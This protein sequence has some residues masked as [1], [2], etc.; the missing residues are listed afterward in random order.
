[1]KSKI[2][3]AV[4]VINAALIVLSCAA[5]FKTYVAWVDQGKF[6]LSLAAVTLICGFAGFF[7][8][9][10]GNGSKK[11][12]I[13]YAVGG[14]AAAEVIFWGFG[15]VIN[16]LIG[17]GGLNKLAG[18]IAVAVIIV[19]YGIVSVLTYKNLNTE[20]KKSVKVLSGVLAAVLAGM[21]V[22]QAGNMAV[23][24]RRATEKNY[25][26]ANECYR[27]D[28]DFY[29]KLKNKEDVNVLII[30]DSIGEGAGGEYG[31]WFQLLENAVEK[32]YGVNYRTR[33]VSFGGNAAYCG[34]VSSKIFADR[35]D[36][37]LAV[38]CYSQNDGDLKT[39][40]IY[41]EAMIRALRT[42]YDNIAIISILESPQR[43]INQKMQ[44]VIDI[45]KYYEIPV[46]DTITPFN[47]SEIGYDNLTT[48]G[49]HPNNEGQKIYFETVM[50][51]IRAE[52]NKNTERFYSMPEPMK[53]EV[54]DFD[55]FRYL[56]ADEFKRIDDVTYEADYSFDNALL[57]LD[58]GVRCG[59]NYV[60][61]FLGGESF[62]TMASTWDFGFDQRHIEPFCSG[63]TAK[64]SVKIVFLNKKAADSFRGLIINPD[65]NTVSGQ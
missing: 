49:V 35:T 12:N 27:Y 53:L 55:R 11:R 50:E 18:N 48:D 51:V 34:Y 57:G 30:G 25:Y 9:Y 4:P 32:E 62:H 54:R 44:T 8:S 37:D 26:D 1:M 61:I 20:N 28:L 63:A 42:K 14:A 33:N 15:I 52:Y 13:L 19:L 7:L 58:F 6:I 10:S 36:Y 23:A 40:G 5:L 22:L 17:K 24:V 46:A 39:L 65:C 45:C 31:I 3:Y 47:T 29:E 38:L 64:H 60:E 43:E 16:T 21:F 41:Y 2:R 59:E 56:R